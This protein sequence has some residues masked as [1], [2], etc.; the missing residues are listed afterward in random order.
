MQKFRSKLK[1]V[2]VLLE[3]LSTALEDNSL[4]QEEIKG[5]VESIRQIVS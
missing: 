1:E 3:K 5:I 4:T 2:K